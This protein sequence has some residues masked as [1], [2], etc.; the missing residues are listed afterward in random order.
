MPLLP[1]GDLSFMVWI[2]GNGSSATAQ[3]GDSAFLSAMTVDGAGLKK[4]GNAK[5]LAR[6]VRAHERMR[7]S[8]LGLSRAKVALRAGPLV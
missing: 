7:D 4:L 6:Y 1:V 8:A 3:D 2:A 5:L